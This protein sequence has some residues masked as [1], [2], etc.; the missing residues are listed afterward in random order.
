MINVSIL[1]NIDHNTIWLMEPK[2]KLEALRL[3]S[4]MP[5][6]GANSPRDLYE[7]P[8]RM[9]EYSLPQFHTPIYLPNGENIFARLF[10][11]I[12][13]FLNPA[14]VISNKA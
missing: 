11:Y 4:G 2:E 5:K 14:L 8:N 7:I 1:F 13:Y 6:R 10:T 3:S 9:N 12:E